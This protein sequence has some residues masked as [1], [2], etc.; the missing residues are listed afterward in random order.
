MPA[1]CTRCPLPTHWDHR[2]H[3]LNGQQKN[4]QMKPSVSEKIK[5]GAFVAVSLL[6]LLVII[7]LI[8]KQQKLFS[9]NFTM[10]ANFR[11][12]NGLII[13]NY[14]RFGGINV[15]IV[16]NIIIKN[17]TTIQVDLRLEDKVKP[18]LRTDALASISSDGLMGDKLIQI[19]PGS[20]STPLLG[21]GGQLKSI[22]P[23]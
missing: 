12:V 13:G 11:N 3:F 7:V 21:E 15:G 23:M 19:F 17:D 18:Y 20:D 22:E 2:D 1:S 9:K 14:V 5:T 16:D 10:R 6:I 8:G 4:S